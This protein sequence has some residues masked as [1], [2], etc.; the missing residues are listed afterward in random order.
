MA[1][2]DRQE[3]EAQLEGLGVDGAEASVLAAKGVS[4]A[5]KVGP[6][7]PPEALVVR[8]EMIALGG[9][10]APGD[11]RLRSRGSPTDV[12]LLG[13]LY[14]HE[15]LVSRLAPLGGPYAE[16]A[17]QLGA[18]LRSGHG[19]T[20]PPLRC[21]AHT[22]ALGVKT[23]VM[24][25]VNL[26][27]D[28]FSGDGLLHEP[29]EAIERARRFVAAGAEII[30]VGGESARADR[31]SLPAEEE[32]RRVIPVV[33][34]LARE[35]PVPVSVDT[36]K[37]AVA[38][39]AVAAGASIINDIAGFTLGTEMAQVAARHGVAL[40][41]NHT[42]ERPKVRPN[43]PPLYSDLMG[44]VVGFLRERIEMARRAGVAPEQLIVDPGIAFGKSHDEDLEVLRRLA[45]LRVLSRPILVGLSRKHFIGS[46]LGSGPQERLEGTLAAA[47][48][49]VAHG[50]DILRVHDVAAVARALRVADAIARGGL[51]DY[52]PS[53]SSW[54][55]PAAAHTD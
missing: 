23:Y 7:E 3:L 9:D 45:E 51:G 24:G 53:P 10:A 34:R 32:V 36:Y 44:A 12:I 43:P 29:E 2:R 55:A 30:D 40:V 21:G 49:A 48:L 47:V 4:W 13:S 17:A 11:E 42:I 26:T 28:S 25:I 31:P 14:Q 18:A 41:I 20:A 1:L 22:L 38:E 6:L 33:E 27:D 54:P 52:A 35:L 15:R 50:A 37:P 8:H 46:V 39:A 16:L 19:G 5:L